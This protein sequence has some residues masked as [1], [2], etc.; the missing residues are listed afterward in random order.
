MLTQIGENM[1]K[2][3]L[4]VSAILGLTTASFAAE[5]E[6]VMGS[7]FRTYDSIS[8][9][10][11][12]LLESKPA[13]TLPSDSKVFNAFAGTVGASTEQQKQALYGALVGESNIKA[14]LS[15]EVAN[16]FQAEKVKAKT[17]I[18]TKFKGM[19]DPVESIIRQ[20]NVYCDNFSGEGDKIDTSIIL[21]PSTLKATVDG[22]ILSI[23]N[24][25]VVTFTDPNDGSTDMVDLLSPVAK[26]HLESLRDKLVQIASFNVGEISSIFDAY[27]NATK[28]IT[29]STIEGVVSKIKAEENDRFEVFKRSLASG[30]D[31]H[32]DRMNEFDDEGINASDIKKTRKSEIKKELSTFREEEEKPN[33]EERNIEERNIEEPKREEP[34]SSFSAEDELELQLHEQTYSKAAK[35]LKIQ[36][37]KA[38]H[39]YQVLKAKKAAAGK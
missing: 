16:G 15:E 11:K 8:V 4:L 19:L 26:S 33:I 31:R 6:E 34:K 12:A 24:G 22:K 3:L 9:I 37:E 35:G 32:E 23:I 21:N 14:E 38:T 39:P 28:A 27:D 36:M 5:R 29:A 2:Q 13:T 18:E 10:G 17:E 30:L 20:F 7:N 25:I 1:K